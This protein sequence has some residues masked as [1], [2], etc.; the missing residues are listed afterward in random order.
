MKKTHV[1]IVGSGNIGCDLMMKILKEPSLQLEMMA[2]IDPCSEGLALAA[3]EGVRTSVNGSRDVVL[4]PDLEVVFEATSAGV[5]QKN[6]VLYRERGIRAIDL[7][8]A[9]LGPFVVPSV[10][11]EQVRKSDN[12]NMVTCGG[13]ATVPMVYAVS[14]VCRVEYAEIISSLSSKSAGP[15]TRKNIDEFTETTAEA[16]RTIGGAEKAKAIIILNPAEPPIAMNNTIFLRVSDPDEEKISASCFEMLERVKEY[17]PGYQ[18]KVPPFISGDKVSMTVQ[19]EG[20]G[21][22]LP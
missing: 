22:Y 8:P 19:V 3:K 6:A 1:A 14:R 5:H 21:D 12:L 11:L 7:T 4:L 15:G 10:N 18:L 2:G 17:V 9:M 20:A 13:Q 16:L